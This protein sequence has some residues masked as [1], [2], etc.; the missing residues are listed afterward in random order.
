MNIAGEL[1]GSGCIKSWLHKST[2][3]TERS[4]KWTFSLHAGKRLSGKTFQR[5]SDSQAL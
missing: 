2:K 1:A 5:P 3:H 4:H